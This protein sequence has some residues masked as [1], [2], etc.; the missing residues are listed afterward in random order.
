MVLPEI[1]G[2]ARQRTE[3]YGERVVKTRTAAECNDK[4]ELGGEVDAGPR[5]GGEAETGVVQAVRQMRRRR[6]AY[7][8][9]GR[10]RPRWTRGWV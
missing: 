7:G 2:L 4:Y 10:R 5:A 1:Q 8:D 6:M 3:E 9:E